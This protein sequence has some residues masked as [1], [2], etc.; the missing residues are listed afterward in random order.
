M[1]S[2]VRTLLALAA[3]AVL[4]TAHAQG[5]PSKPVRVIVPY[6]PGGGLDFAA[7][8]VSSKMADNTGQPFVVENRPGASGIVGADALIKSPADGYTIFVGDLASL[9]LNPI[10][11]AKLPYDPFKDFAPVARLLRAALMLVVPAD[12]PIASVKDAVERAKASP[13]KMNYGIPGVGSPHHLTMELFLLTVGAKMTH[14]AFKGAAPAVQELITGRLDAMFV[15]L[16]TGGPQLRGGKLKGLAVAHGARLPQFPNVATVAE[17]GYPG[18]DAF[19]WSGIVVAA[20]TPRE[21]VQR[22]NAEIGKTMAD[23]TV[24]QKL[25]EVGFEALPG[26]PEAL[27]QFMREEQVKWRKVID[28]AQIR[29][30]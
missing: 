27:T 30:E 20:G 4:G 5:F 9:S 21:F 1:R 12:S 11:Y 25:A 29:V 23:S 26:P 3:L 7:R 15:D 16:G 6:P 2:I 18:F 24:Q 14:V 13:G 17:S 8:L 28:A 22:L 19:A 10:L